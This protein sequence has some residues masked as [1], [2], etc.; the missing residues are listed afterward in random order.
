MS[1]D[2]FRLIQYY[3]LIDAMTTSINIFSGRA[4]LH[5]DR[6]GR[7]TCR[8][9]MLALYRDL[10]V[11]FLAIFASEYRLQGTE[12]RNNLLKNTAIL[13]RY[14]ERI[15]RYSRFFNEMSNLRKISET[16]ETV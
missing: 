3:I 12:Y 4:Y 7:T 11:I 13:L 16:V 5:V 8:V 10:V 1:I 15:L 9:F 14:L 6:F 2:R